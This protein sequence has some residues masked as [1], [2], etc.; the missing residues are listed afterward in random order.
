MRLEPW[1]GKPRRKPRS[2]P[3]RL[4]PP[5]DSR[6]RRLEKRSTIVP[7]S[8]WFPPKIEPT[9]TSE[10]RLYLAE[11]QD[12]YPPNNKIEFVCH[13]RPTLNPR[14]RYR[15]LELC[16]TGHE[17]Q[18]FAAST[19]CGHI[20]PHASSSRKNQCSIPGEVSEKRPARTRN[21]LR[22]SLFRS[23]IG[24]QGILRMSECQH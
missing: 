18:R 15:G 7:R 16:R 10:C 23:P 2:A 20:G 5:Q 9:T 24:L 8:S 14:V 4:C 11:K 19:T 6:F 12:G 3:P 21:L 17:H 22:A 13:S 1:R